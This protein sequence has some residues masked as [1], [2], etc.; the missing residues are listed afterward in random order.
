MKGQRRRLGSSRADL[1]RPLGPREAARRVCAEMWGDPP[2]ERTAATRRP[3]HAV[4]LL[5]ER[6]RG[7]SPMRNPGASSPILRRLLLKG[8]AAVSIGLGSPASAQ[9]TAPKT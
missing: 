4:V 3:W 5:K 1:D 6:T 8:G 2:N 9:V 7:A